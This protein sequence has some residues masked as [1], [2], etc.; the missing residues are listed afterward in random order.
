MLGVSD[1]EVFTQAIGKFFES[2]TRHPAQVRS[3]YLVEQ[4]NAFPKADFSGLISLGGQYD[5]WVC[6]S[7]P[8]GLLSQVLVSMGVGSY[9][10]AGHLDLVGE[11]AN[12]MIGQAQRHFGATLEISVPKTFPGSAGA[13]PA[14]QLEGRTLVLPMSWFGYEA[15]LALQVQKLKN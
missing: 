5:G 3:A 15:S 1:I 12:T 13:M 2:V 6:F 4:G 11:I 7:A 8:R 14:P 9:T 10:D